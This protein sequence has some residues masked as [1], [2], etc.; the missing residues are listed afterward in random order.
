MCFHWRACRC[1][2]SLPVTA[3]GRHEA[4]YIR[5]VLAV[6]VLL[7]ARVAVSWTPCFSQRC[8]ML[9]AAFSLPH[10][11]I[12]RHLEA[13]YSPPG[14]F[15]AIPAP[16]PSI[17]FL[18]HAQ[19]SGLFHYLPLPARATAAACLTPSVSHPMPMSRSPMAASMPFGASVV[20]TRLLHDCSLDRY[21][22]GQSACNVR[23][24][25]C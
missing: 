24:S 12:L 23:L 21:L 9:T 6:E 19:A 13:R 4:D 1:R 18:L 8:R 5:V 10:P 3:P 15:C 16:V 17:D 7:S 14:A 22:R 2:V 11:A 25:S 20:S